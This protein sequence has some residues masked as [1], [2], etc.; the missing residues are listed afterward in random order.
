MD[1][2]AFATSS[3]A[4]SDPIRTAWPN[5]VARTATLGKPIVRASKV[6]RR[7]CFRHHASAVW[8]AKHQAFQAMRAGSACSSVASL[9]APARPRVVLPAVVRRAERTSLRDSLDKVVLVS[10]SAMIRAPYSLD[11]GQAGYVC[12]HASSRSAI[13]TLHFEMM[14]LNT[15]HHIMV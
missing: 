6:S 7:C 13:E 2:V 5:S 10:E 15:N 1:G 14:L 12:P 3:N 11:C 8:W 4:S 9:A